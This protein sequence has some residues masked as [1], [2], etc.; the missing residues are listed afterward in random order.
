MSKG[1]DKFKEVIK[2]YLDKLA[3]EDY[4]FAPK[5]ANP[6]KN[7][8]E[9]VDYIIGE[10][11]K[12]G[13]QGFADEEIFG[14][15]VHYYDEED[16]KVKKAKVNQVVV[17]HPIELTEAEKE[18]LRK[19]VEAEERRKAE[20]EYKEKIRKELKS[21]KTNEAKEKEK[22]APKNAEPKPATPKKDNQ[23][24][25]FNLLIDEA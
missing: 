17:N 15:A 5:Y 10:V 6:K 9:C 14:M 13:R 22:P 2:A 11:Q 1:T 25:L 4:L 12:S 7:I 18:K 23:L 8:N 3:A 21:K 24:D 19:Q 16:L 20:L